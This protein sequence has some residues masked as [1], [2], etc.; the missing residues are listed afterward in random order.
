MISN[1]VQAEDLS[2]ILKL[3][4]GGGAVLSVVSACLLLWRGMRGLQADAALER[5]DLLGVAMAAQARMADDHAK[6]RVETR[7][8][9]LDALRAEHED[10][11]AATVQLTA[12]ID[13][14]KTTLEAK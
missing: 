4:A 5:K 9:F 14:L 3:V 1:L 13:R 10:N 8:D 12:A 2:G 11:R 7:K 6:E